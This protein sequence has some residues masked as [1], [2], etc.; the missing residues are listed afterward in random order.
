MHLII[1][2]LL[3]V[4][5]FLLT[6][7]RGT[8]SSI[9]IEFTVAAPYAPP[10]PWVRPSPPARA[11]PP[12]EPDEVVVQREATAPKARPKT[13]KAQPVVQ[14]NLTKVTRYEA[15]QSSTPVQ[16]AKPLSQT[17]IRR[18]LAMG[19]KPGTETVIP[20]VE[21]R[22]FDTIRRALYNAWVQ[23][24]ADDAGNAVVEV[25]IQL[26]GGGV[27]NGWRIVKRSGV[28]IMDASVARALQGTKQI[29]GLTPA[30]IDRHG[31]VT[32]AFR[33]EQ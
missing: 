33:V 25:E 13:A 6:C 22:S 12:P 4:S 8:P 11:A 29:Q 30:F 2:A 16:S 10:E 28:G 32:I 15:V 14:R 1:V 26:G 9:P 31:T 24:S 23:P 5:S 3:L 20:D 19:A 21:A 18:L 17:E 7:F 27:V